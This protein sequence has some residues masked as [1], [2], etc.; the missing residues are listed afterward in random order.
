MNSVE[1]KQASQIAL[2]IQE[3]GII[4]I[5]RGDFPLSRLRDIASALID[6]GILVLEITLTVV[7]RKFRSKVRINDRIPTDLGLQ[8]R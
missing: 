2:Q 4:A 6:S 8:S 7:S 3:A 1:N 5:I